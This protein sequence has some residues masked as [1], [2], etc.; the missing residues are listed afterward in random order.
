MNLFSTN[1]S[2]IGTADKLAVD[3]NPRKRANWLAVLI[4][5]LLAGTSLVGYAQTEEPCQYGIT[6]PTGISLALEGT[7]TLPANLKKRVP[8]VVLIAGSGPTDRNGNS[9]V[10]GLQ[11]MNM[12]RQLADSLAKQGVAVLRYDKRGSGTNAL[13]YA[14]QFKKTVLNFGDGVADA[15][16]FIRQLQADRRFSSVTVAGHSEGSLV[17]M[18]AATQTKAN[19]FISIA[20]AGQNIADIIKVQF[21]NGGVEGDMLA[22]AIRDLDSLKAGK[23][24]RQPPAMLTSLFSPAAQ[25]YL[26]SW[27]KYDPAVVIRA[28]KGPVLIVQGRRD[29]QVATSEADLLK[30][31]RPDA[32]LIFFETMN[33]ILKEAPAERIANM[34]VYTDPKRTIL[35]AVADEIARFVR[36]K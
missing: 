2:P 30:A 15:V 21:A 3:D 27:M 4:I 20:G 26:I 16:G 17:G 24:V 10:P 18:L 36:K 5:I 9:S 6:S 13:L 22:T 12:L 25:P 31:A 8:V 29:I 19:R 35:P 28:F 14:A 1:H 23:T 33:H 11:Q 7:L 34:A 32:R